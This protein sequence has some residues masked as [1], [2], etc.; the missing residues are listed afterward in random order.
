MAEH[1]QET[2]PDHR[3]ARGAADQ[4]D[5]FDLRSSEVGGS[6]R[7]MDR[8]QGLLDIGCDHR[9]VLVA[10]QFH[11][12]VDRLAL[13]LGQ[14]LFLDAGERVIGQVPLRR[15]GGAQDARHRARLGR[16]IDRRSDLQM[17]E[18]VGDD[19]LVEIVA[20]QVVVAVAG[21]DLDHAFFDPHHQTSK[22]PPPRS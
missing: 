13:D 11:R 8:L 17:L 22:V 5:L 2:A 19:L 15:L 21:D 18:D 9:F 10:R 14:V 1:L 12:Q 3:R 6:Q 4:Q 20:A 16:H 7:G